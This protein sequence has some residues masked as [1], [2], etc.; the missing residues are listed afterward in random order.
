MMENRALE[1]RHVSKSFKLPHEKHTSL[2]SMFIKPFSGKKG[3]E[4]Q[5]VLKDISFEV[6][7]GEFFGIVGRNGGGKS[8]LLKLLASIYAPDKGVVQ[9]NGK[10]VPFIELGVG[11]NPELTGRDNIYL[12]GALLGF[13]DKEIDEIY[14]DIVEFAELEKFMDQKLKNYSSGMQVRLA[15]SVA[16]RSKADILLV[17][18]VLAVGD[19]A[20]Q[21][22]CY[23]YFSS[24]KRTGKTVIFIS[25]DMNAIREYCDRVMLIEKGEVVEVGSAEKIAEEYMRLFAGPQAAQKN[26]ENTSRWGDE[27]IRLKASLKE[28]TEN[29]VDMATIVSAKE[30]V[31][32]IEVG[33][34]ILADDGAVVCGVN[35]QLLKQK[36][37]KLKKGDKV[38]INWKVPNIFRDGK[39]R[40]TVAA[41][42]YGGMPVYDWWNNALQFE[43]HFGKQSPYPVVPDVKLKITSL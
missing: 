40:V 28:V 17:D 16:T 32:D 23:D 1:I 13:S 34:S 31:G 29:F 11:F 3:Y 35:T 39:Y 12:N 18:E 6:Q 4:R 7:K 26:N 22:K 2:K 42:G 19:V 43:S 10:L 8:T 36:L 25:H 38:E 37:P 24:L 33:I 5:H 15:F 9:V 41:H 30:D 14:D 20:F 21:R 27:S